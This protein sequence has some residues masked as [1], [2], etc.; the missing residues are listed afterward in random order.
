MHRE[1]G[2]GGALRASPKQGM[3]VGSRAWQTARYLKFGAMNFSD[4]LGIIGIVLAMIS[5]VYAVY[6]TRERK[7]LEEYVRSQAWYIYSKA[8]NV[9]GIAQAGLGTYKQAHAQNLNTQVLELMAKTD[10]FGQ[11]LFRE[12]IR[13]IQL[14]EP[15]FT[16]NQIDIWVSDGKLDKDHAALFKALCVSN[17]APSGS[18]KRTPHG[19][20]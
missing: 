3:C 8:N 19:A 9:T 14:A 18:S 4:I 12:T 15:D 7:K 16:H 6:Q 10:A 5:L 17:N 1:W 13:Q 2:A 20:A 11:D